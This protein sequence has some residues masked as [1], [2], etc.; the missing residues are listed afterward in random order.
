MPNEIVLDGESIA[1][2]SFK[3]EKINDLHQISV[4]FPVTS[5]EYHRITTLLY[6][7]I[8][9]VSVPEIEL[10]FRGTI[11]QYFTSITDLYQKGNTGEFTLTL[12]EIKE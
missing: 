11:K 5:E 6:K 8:F 9:D 7:E 2:A 10:S 12:L 1:V 3:Q 4:V